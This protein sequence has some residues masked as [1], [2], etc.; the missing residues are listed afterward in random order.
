MDSNMKIF[1]CQV[2]FTAEI[3]SRR[4][5]CW[6]SHGDG[7][8]NCYQIFGR[9]NTQRRH[10]E[11]NVGEKS[12]RFKGSGCEKTTYKNE[13]HNK[14]DQNCIRCQGNLGTI[15]LE[16]AKVKEFLLQNCRYLKK[17]FS[18]LL[19]LLSSLLQLWWCRSIKYFG[20]W[21]CKDAIL[22]FH[23]HNIINVQNTHI[24]NLQSV[25]VHC[26]S[27]VWPCFLRNSQTKS[28]RSLFFTFLTA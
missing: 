18:L 7:H 5:A 17:I 22:P 26:Y 21:L 1:Y 3:R 13:R 4:L 25:S 27:P 12:W 10:S 15:V 28:E 9:R 2:D 23:I 19:W 11:E 8:Q 14:M 20:Y 16:S 24:C 6:D